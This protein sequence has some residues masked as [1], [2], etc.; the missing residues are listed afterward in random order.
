MGKD[1]LLKFLG[2]IRG[3]ERKEGIQKKLNSLVQK[4]SERRDITNGQQR[5]GGKP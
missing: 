5:N 3:G 1:A 4:A 2:D